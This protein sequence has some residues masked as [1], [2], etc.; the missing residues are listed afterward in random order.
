[1]PAIIQQ[2]VVEPKYKI[3]MGPIGF[4]YVLPILGK[5]GIEPETGAAISRAANIERSGQLSPDGQSRTK[6]TKEDSGKEAE[7]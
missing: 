2:R 1:M 3:S 7:E 5:K 6:G 4:S